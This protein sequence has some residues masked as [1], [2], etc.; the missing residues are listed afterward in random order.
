MSGAGSAN[1]NHGFDFGIGGDIFQDEKVSGFIGPIRGHP[2]IGESSG[3][4]IRGGNGGF[5]Q[6]VAGGRL[7]IKEGDGKK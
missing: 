7:S 5:D 3:V 1:F 4:V 2:L 6:H